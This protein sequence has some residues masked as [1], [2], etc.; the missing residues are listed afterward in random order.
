MTALRAGPGGVDGAGAIGAVKAG[1]TTAAALYEDAV[2]RIEGY[3][4]DLGAVSERIP[5]QPPMDGPLSGMMLG[6]KTHFDVAGCRN[7]FGLQAMGMDAEPVDHD[8]TVVARLRRAGATLVC[9]TAAP[10]IGG[11]GGVTPQTRNPRSLDRVSGGS[12]GGSASAVAAGLVHAALG[13][14]SGGSIRIPAACCGVVGLQTTRGL[15]PLTR[16]GGLTYTMDSVGPL[17]SNVGDVRI[18]LEVM[19]GFDLEDPYSVAVDSPEGWN[20]SPLRIGLPIELVDWNVDAEVAEAFETVVEVIGA[21]GHRVDRVSLP[22]LREAME[23]GPRTI[24]LIE[25]GAIIEDAFAEVT[26]DVPELME[27]VARSKEF[28]GPTLARANHRIAVLRSEVRHLFNAYDL[29]LTP[30]LPCLIPDGSASDRE[31][32]IE[33]GGSLESRTSALTRLVNPW[34]LAAVPAGSLPIGRD[35]GG[36]PISIQVI[37]PQFSD[38]KVLDVM[39]FIEASLGGPWDTVAP[40]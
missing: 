1:R 37:G 17:A 24:G 38:W 8:A 30:T 33:V 10:F 14:D 39:Q 29:L 21:A 22:R 23:L 20:G 12:S 36:A 15:V 32:Q 25:S 11:P 28:S 13:S 31:V 6:V 16:S 26:A 9:T 19:A 27:A 4:P 3:E 5:Y 18:L 7:W 40:T 34:N 2:R 35:P